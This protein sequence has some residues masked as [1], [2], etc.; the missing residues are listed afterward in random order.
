LLDVEEL[1]EFV[2]LEVPR[3][4]LRGCDVAELLGKP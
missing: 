2:S 3:Y 4:G 1:I